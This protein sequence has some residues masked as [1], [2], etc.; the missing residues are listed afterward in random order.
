M[1]TFEA[2]RRGWFEGA[3]SST[4][5]T[6]ST[7]GVQVVEFVKGEEYAK[8]TRIVFDTAPTG[9]TLRL[10]A[11]P[12]F[13]EAALGK[14]V[15]LRKK[16]GAAGDAVRGL[17]GASQQQDSAVEKL[18]KL[19]VR[20]LPLQ[21]VCFSFFF[22]PPFFPL[23]HSLLSDLRHSCRKAVVLC[24]L[25]EGQAARSLPRMQHVFVLYI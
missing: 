18:E 3:P 13:V 20:F 11:V 7:R 5:L 6:L 12:D 19:R 2:V 25:G 8:F 15:R 22:S 24:C 14:I 1:G 21:N 4:G 16:L 23:F 9:H 10:L 17:F